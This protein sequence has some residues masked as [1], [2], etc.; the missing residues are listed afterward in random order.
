MF[1]SWYVLGRFPKARQWSF[2]LLSGCVIRNEQGINPESKDWILEGLPICQSRF[3][4]YCTLKPHLTGTMMGLREFLLELLLPRSPT[5]SWD[6]HQG[7]KSFQSMESSGSKIHSVINMICE[8]FAAKYAV[9]VPARVWDSKV[10]CIEAV[11]VTTP[12]TPGMK[13]ETNVGT[14]YSVHPA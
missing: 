9:A 1:D 12:Y 6:Q 14:E 13:V 3:Y 8:N 11:R 4:T 5:G 2:G 10:L 7:T